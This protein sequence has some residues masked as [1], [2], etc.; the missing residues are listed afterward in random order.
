M[1]NFL[2]KHVL[3][4]DEKTLEFINLNIQTNTFETNNDVYYARYTIPD[5]D[6]PGNTKNDLDWEE[7]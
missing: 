5:P 1:L 3:D 4:N 7:F 2:D 6:N